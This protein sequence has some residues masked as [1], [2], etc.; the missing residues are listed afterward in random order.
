MSAAAAI[1]MLYTQVILYNGL[2]FDFLLPVDTI[3][4]G[5]MDLSK[6]TKQETDEAVLRSIEQC[7]NGD[8]VSVEESVEKICT[9]FNIPIEKMRPEGMKASAGGGEKPQQQPQIVCPKGRKIN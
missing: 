6:M 8:A 4:P 7:K 1:D 9:A 3:I 5:I 2:P